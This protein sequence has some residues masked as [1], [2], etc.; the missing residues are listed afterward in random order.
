MRLAAKAHLA[1]VARID[2]ARIDAA[3]A[4]VGVDLQTEPPADL[5][6]GDDAAAHGLRLE[7][8][9]VDSRQVAAAGEGDAGRRHSVAARAFDHAAEP[10]VLQPARDGQIEATAFSVGDERAQ[11]RRWWLGEIDGA[12]DAGVE[13]GVPQ[14]EMRQQQPVVT[15]GGAQIDVGRGQWRLA[16]PLDDE[17]TDVQPLDQQIEGEV[18]NGQFDRWR[19]LFIAGGRELPAQRL[20]FQIADAQ[21]TLPQ[22]RETVVDGDAAQLDVLSVGPD[23]D[24]ADGG[25]A[26]EIAMHV[27][28]GDHSRPEHGEPVDQPAAAGV[29]AEGPEAEGECGN[30]GEKNQPVERR[31]Q[32]PHRSGPMLRCRR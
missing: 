13:R 22:W 2:G 12:A 30:D 9:D 16:R 8:V 21:P 17:A 32:M 31:E 3:A 19:C 14:L 10:I 11:L 6:V 15:K 18:Q 1:G 23:G 20:D 29:A 25:A 4:E 26:D 27:G 24:A 28:D 5:A 7:R